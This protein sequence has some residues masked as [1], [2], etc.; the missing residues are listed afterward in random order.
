M[1]RRQAAC[2]G[3][4][5]KVSP[6]VA[7]NEQVQEVPEIGIGRRPK[8]GRERI[9]RHGDIGEDNPRRGHACFG[10]SAAANRSRRNHIGEGHRLTT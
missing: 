8:Q 6:G 10:V 4:N 5:D 1:E 7:D 3:K 2:H 9:V